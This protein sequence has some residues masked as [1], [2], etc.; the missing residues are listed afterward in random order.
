LTAIYEQ[1]GWGI[2]L[3]FKTK[4]HCMKNT[5][6]MIFGALIMSLSLAC[7][8][9]AKAQLPT[10]SALI[11]DHHI[12]HSISSTEE[13]AQVESSINALSHQL[14]GSFSNYPNLRVIPAFENDELIGFIITGVS[15]S[16][17]ADRISLILLELEQL[18]K[19]AKNSDMKFLPV[20]DMNSSRV[21][22][23]ESR[24]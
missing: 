2:H 7:A 21:S 10:E 19:M 3:K 14:C 23:R 15:D 24:L 20:G 13:F 12:N 17:E 4:N 9:E 22:K 11:S 5:S 6:R 16:K 18:S 8:L 1:L